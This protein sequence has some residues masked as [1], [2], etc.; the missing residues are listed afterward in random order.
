MAVLGGTYSG[1]PAS[2]LAAKVAMTHLVEHEDEIY[3]RLSDLGRKVRDAL[4]TGFAEEG[5]LARCTGSGPELPFGSSLAMVHFPYDEGTEIT[6]PEDV[7]DP[8]VCDVALRAQVLGPALLL[9]GVH[10]VQGHGSAATTH[11]DEDMELL[12]EACRRVARRVKPY[13]TEHSSTG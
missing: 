12:K 2:M 4:E 3:P 6:T 9:E 1:H 10:M 11:S 5:I 13:M 7:H 8:T